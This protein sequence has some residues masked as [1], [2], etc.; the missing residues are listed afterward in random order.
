MN[1][2]NKLKSILAMALIYAMVLTVSVPLTS[3][4]TDSIQTDVR[5]AKLS[6][7]FLKAV[8]AMDKDE[9]S[10]NA[11]MQITRAHFVKLALHLSNDAPN[12]LVSDDEV[13][14]DV[15]PSTVYENY[16]ETAY[17]IGY[18]SGS[19]S[20]LFQPNDPITLTQAI[21]II[22]NVLGYNQYAEA[23]GGYPSGYLVTAQRIKLLRD[24][25]TDA[26]ATLDMANAVILLENA[27]KTE[28]MQVVSIGEN[29]EM[30]S[31]KGQT[32]LYK[33]HGIDFIE[34]IVEADSYTSLLSTE[35]SLS[36]NQLSISGVS[37]N[38]TP[39]ILKDS[40]GYNVRLYFDANSSSTL[41]DALY[42]EFTEEN[43]FVHET[44][45]DNISIENDK[46]SV[47]IDED[48]TRAITI[49][50]DVSYILNG[51]MSLM[52]PEDLLD[53]KKGSI[54]F[55]SND[56]DK[57]V[58]VIKV[59]KYDTAMVNGVSASS[60]IIVTN[61]GARINLDSSD[62]SYSFDIMRN[63][64]AADIT[65][66]STGDVILIA[67]GQGRGYRHIS[68][69]ATNKIIS[70]SI[71]EKAD[72][73]VII[74][75]K[76]Y[77]LD[78]A[79]AGIKPGVNY[80][81]YFDAF[82]NVCYITNDADVVYGFL[83]A[84]DKQSMNKPKCMIFTENNRWVELNFADKVKYNGTS[85]SAD[86]LYL[87][88]TA[89]GD[90]YKQLIRYNVNS[91]PELKSLETY[92]NIPIGDD[93]EKDAIANNK[94]RLSYS[95]SLRYRNSPKSFNG[96]FFVDSDAKIFNIPQDLSKDKFVVRGI[97]ALKTDTA[98]NIT[99]FNADK[100]LTSGILTT[101]DLAVDN[102]IIHTDKFMIVKGKGQIV[103]GEGGVSPSV[104][105][106]WDG[107]EI[108]FPVKI[109]DLGV[110]NE[111]Y[112]NLEKGDV[113]LFKYDEDSNIT[114]I[115][116][117]PVYSAYYTSSNTLYTTCAIVGGVVSE[118]DI[119]GQKIRMTYSESGSEL[120]VIYTTSTTAAIWDKKSSTYT[121]A[122]VSD[123]IPGDKIFINTRY[124][125]CYD[126]II[127][128]D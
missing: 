113:I 55:I 35:S 118:I 26:N 39:Q 47:S 98:Y 123:I 114:A 41:K 73:F 52:N 120:G 79:V 48:R 29:V 38:A 105:G 124:L 21:K 95:G 31:F 24:I 82:D 16:I 7:E 71:D 128:R 96:V 60:G 109:G 4:A 32:L 46:I 87:Q 56:G 34:G 30:Q 88:L 69:V 51:K 116:E 111:T 108:S 3:F 12:V 9:V 23:Y 70:G 92:V 80:K 8:G 2:L 1:F 89:M 125:N 101:S 67:E 84:V 86:D 127:I 100:Y 110:S 10:Y 19:S 37:F 81:I 49:S 68:I 11:T 115:T 62:D 97:S 54:K 18:I 33:N 107:I 77:S 15:N 102:E 121:E 76:K 53:V 27:A 40:L 28:I 112:N 63:S 14:Y 5:D 43:T 91:V 58:D 57:S 83:Y 6:Y 119:T 99:A 93:A 75:G 78:T 36:K 20:G 72:D 66:L 94:F 50:P 45:W 122:D 103:N 22:C 59:L 85:V 126:V 65:D 42:A 117:Y 106:Y 74:S 17:R 104:I 61:D 44:T 25:N 64:Y 90:D 13:F